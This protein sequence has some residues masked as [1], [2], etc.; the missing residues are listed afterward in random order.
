[1]KILL[2]DSFAVATASPLPIVIERL[3]HKIQ[4]LR[5][6]AYSADGG[7]PYQGNISESGFRISRIAYR[8]LFVPVIRGEFSQE[9]DN[10]TVFVEISMHPAGI[11]T[12]FFIVLTL[13]SMAG[14]ISLEINDPKLNLLLW[15]MPIM[16]VVI[17]YLSFW[18]DAKTSRNELTATIEGRI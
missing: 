12:L 3:N 11:G 16:L 15:S 4:P 18:G 13:F 9:A 5:T 6:F 17:T 14:S 2:Y 1:M 8:N 7:P 10:T